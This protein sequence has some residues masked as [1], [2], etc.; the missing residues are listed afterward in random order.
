M[1]RLSLF[2]ERSEVLLFLGGG[3][4]FLGLLVNEGDFCFA[5]ELMLVLGH[6]VAPVLH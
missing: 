1:A 5:R 2:L 6:R 4:L 3:G